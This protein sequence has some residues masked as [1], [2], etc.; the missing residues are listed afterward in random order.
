MPRVT[1]GY[2]R[3]T[4]LRFT[5]GR[6]GGWPGHY[7]NR[8]SDNWQPQR[9]ET[10]HPGAT[11]QVPGPRNVPSPEGAT[12]PVRRAVVPPL[13]G[14]GRVGDSPPG[15]LPQAGMPRPVGAGKHRRHFPH[16]TLRQGPVT[17]DG[18]G[19]AARFAMN[20]RGQARASSTSG[21]AWRTQLRGSLPPEGDISFNVRA[22]WNLWILPG[23][24]LG[25]ALQ[26]RSMVSKR[27]EMAL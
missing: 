22:A 8:F 20:S 3:R 18:G 9:G 14:F 19:T 5:E 6:G 15:A 2:S 7:L 24:D 1:H 11:P 17:A 23:L 10:Y 13:Q 25:M 27:L 16:L 21:Y 4:A 12:Q 26:F